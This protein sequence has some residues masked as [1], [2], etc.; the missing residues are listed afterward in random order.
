MTPRNFHFPNRSRSRTTIGRGLSNDIRIE[1]DRRERMIS[2]QHVVIVKIA[3]SALLVD[4]SLNG[5]YVNHRRVRRCL[6]HMNDVIR[7]GKNRRRNSKTNFVFI[8][9]RNKSSS[10]PLAITDKHSDSHELNLV[11]LKSSVQC[12]KCLDY[13]VIPTTV[14]PCNDHFCNECIEDHFRASDTCPSCHSP[15]RLLETRPNPNMTNI[16]DKVLGH[17]FGGSSS[18]YKNFTARLNQRK[19]I[20]NNRHNQ[21]NQLVTKFQTIESESNGSTDPFLTI[22]QTWTQFERTK[23]SKGIANYPIGDPR[24]YYCWIV[25]LTPEWIL[26]YANQTELSVA[27]GNLGIARPLSEIS[28]EQMQRQ[29]I[30]FIYSAD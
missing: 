8:P 7:L 30:R 12:P 20:L 16:I 29:L 9:A 10:R 22:Y 5:T 3:D 18:C 13:M 27:L 15:V 4:T 17:I 25:G 1:D 11:A 24:T 26:H 2:L 6:L 21:L 23:F 19:S 28:V 14:W